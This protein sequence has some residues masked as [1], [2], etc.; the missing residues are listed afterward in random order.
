M[1][2]VAMSTALPKPWTVEEFLAWEAQQEE[3]FELLDGVVFMMV[4][5]SNAHTAIK[6]NVFAT[7][8]DRLRGGPCRAFV[9]GP[10]IVTATDTLY[11]DVVVACGTVEMAD[12]RIPEPTVIVEILSR[13]TASRDRGMKWT[14]YQHL[15]SLRHYLMVSQDRRRI[16]IYS[17][18]A[19]AW[20]FRTVEP[21]AA[22]VALPELGI[23]L[24]VD[25][26][27]E[28]SGV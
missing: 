14:A 15:S 21:P 17:R 20:L 27:Y 7:L 9:D 23:A 22:E 2:H 28:D 25:E 8:R 5:G 26:I 13:S 4:G 3:K 11:P 12:D 19:E 10:K 24:S 1:Y 18:T 6:G 16:E